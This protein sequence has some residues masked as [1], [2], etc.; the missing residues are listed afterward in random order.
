MRQ[1]MREPLGSGQIVYLSRVWVPEVYTFL[2]I[3]RMP[4]KIAHFSSRKFYIQKGG[5]KYWPP[6][7]DMHAKVFM[8]KMYW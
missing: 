1:S 7:N 5:N 4:I 2:K 6:V 8:G 3:Q